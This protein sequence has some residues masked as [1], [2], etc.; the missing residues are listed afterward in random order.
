[1]L[2]NLLNILYLALIGIFGLFFVLVFI[3]YFYG[4]DLPSF[5]KLSYY[6]PR[7][8]SKIFTSNGNFLEDY[9]TENRVFSS[10]EEIPKELINCFL[11]S[12]DINFF[13]HIGID[14]KGIVRAFLKNIAKTFTNKRLE[15]ASTI[16]QQVA[17]NFLL[18]NEISYT[19]KIKEII[20]ALRMEKVLEKKQIMEL[21]LNEIYLGN[22][23]YGIASASL[24]YFNKSLSSL[25]LHEM[26]MLAALPKAPSTYNP[27]K[28]PIKAMK[29]RNW[30]LK[31]LFDEKYIDLETY[32]SV[33]NEKLVLSKSKKILNDNASF[34][35]EEIRREII[36][37]FTESKLY[38]GGLT[39]MTTLDEDLQLIAEESFRFGL[40]S[41]SFRNGWKGPLMNI[42]LDKKDTFFDLKDP[43]GIYDDELGLV[44]KVKNEYIEVIN[45]KNTKFRLLKNQMSLI[46][47]KKINLKNLFKIG[48]VIVVSANENLNSYKL[49]QIPDVNGG[50]VVIDNFTGRVL[51]MVGGYDSSSSFNRVTQAKRQL[52]SSFKPFVYIAAL[53]NGYTPVSKV[54]DAPFVIDDMS[55]DGVWRPTNYGDKFYGLSTL[56]LGI[57]KSRNLMTIRLSDQVGIEKVAKISRKLG[58]YDK[59]PLLISSSLGSLESSLIKI[60]SGYASI[61]NGGY[62][63]EP[64]MIDVI[65]DKK[66][67]II[68]NGDNRKCQRCN[69]KKDNYS[70]F[71]Q[72]ELP[73]IKNNSERIFSEDSA[74][75]MTSFLMGVIKRGTAKN[76]NK[77]NYQIAGKTGTTNENQDAWFIGYNSEIT[78]GV[79]VGYDEP[80]SLG[81]F[82]TGSRVAA[83]IFKDFMSKSY[84]QNIPKPFN[85]PDSIKFINIDL[86]S[87]KPSNQNFITESFKYNFNFDTNLDLKINESDNELKGFY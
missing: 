14:Y 85:I 79:F 56:R 11:V 49:S 31:R 77:F 8:V 1:M 68:F 13:K 45:K 5:D 26:A 71:N 4:K 47:K 24:N 19:R 20:I 25:D 61:A 42:N 12:E 76:I 15:G 10:Y 9:S 86:F 6:Q 46:K 3:F 2:K 52:G 75:Q 55:K 62:K 17:K 18:T 69:I 83:P 70:S 48:D 72:Y 50:M 34:F 87:G 28:N 80:K 37:K 27:Y 66:G 36:S 63:V 65:Y 23:S 30:V 82:E 58:I 67:K 40:K 21:Y 16:T 33:L 7:L 59:F 35:K 39:I 32:T 43:E 84:P 29:R 54:L 73:K 44:T 64:R 74:Y 53:E 60:T 38:D 57:E 78:V 41:Y 22:G 81:K 51:A